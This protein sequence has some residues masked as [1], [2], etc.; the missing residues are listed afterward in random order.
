VIPKRSYGTG[1]IYV[2][3]GNWYGRWWVGDQ[4]V[5]RK[6]GAVRDPGSRT[7]LTQSR[8]ER[9]MRRRMDAETASVPLGDRFTVAQAG[10]RLIDQL[11]LHGLRPTT[12]TVYRSLLR[13]HLARHLGERELARV[14]PDEV[15]RIFAVMRRGGAGPKLIKNALTLLG[16]IFDHGIDKGSCRANQYDKCGGPGSSSP[17]RSV[18]SIRPSLK[19]FCAPPRA[20]RIASSFSPQQ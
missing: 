20:T 13:T 5:K 1:P 16:Q 19:H 14:T 2:R 15:E 12:I 4:R 9:E 17:T 11:E 6:L 7:G 3:A 8:A 18:T 10:E